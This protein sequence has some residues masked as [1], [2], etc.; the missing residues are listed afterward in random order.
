VDAHVLRLY[1]YCRIG[2]HCR[3]Q[4]HLYYQIF[5]RQCSN[6]SEGQKLALPGSQL[7]VMRISKKNKKI[8]SSPLPQLLPSHTSAIAQ[9]TQ[10]H[11][12]HSTLQLSHCLR[13]ARLATVFAT[14]GCPHR[15]KL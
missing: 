9:P 2:E 1:H 4:E 6:G 7:A 10:I 15:L 3:F 5:I 11:A 12:T 14:T 8:Q 13:A